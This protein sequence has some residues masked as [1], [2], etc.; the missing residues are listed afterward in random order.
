MSSGASGRKRAQLTRPGSAALRRC[1]AWVR[2]E[3]SSIRRAAAGPRRS[4]WPCRPAPRPRR[5]GSARA[6]PGHVGRALDHV[7]AAAPDIDGAGDAGLVEAGTAG[8]CGT[9]MQA[10]KSGRQRDRLVERVGVQSSG[11]WPATAA[12]ASTMV[13]ATLLS[14]SCAARLQPLVWVWARSAGAGGHQRSATNS[15]RIENLGPEHERAARCLDH[16]HGSSSC[17]RSRRTT[18]AAQKASTVIPAASAGAHVFDVRRRGCRPS[19]RSSSRPGFTACG[20]R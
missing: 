15:S 13:R 3:A 2:A 8:C 1:E 16:L 10:E 12:I 11:S 4:P 6:P 5:C 19:S 20:S 14:T 9:T 17:R 7:V 18:G